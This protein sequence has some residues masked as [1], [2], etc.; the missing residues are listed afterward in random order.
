[1]AG[2]PSKLTKQVEADLTA[3]L[4]QGVAVKLAA[5]AT[6]VSPRSVRRWLNEGGLRERVAEVRDAERTPVD[7]ARA[8]AR[9]VV[10]ILKAAEHDWRASAWW[11][12]RRWPERWGDARMKASASVRE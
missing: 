11:L 5:S 7:D 1:M 3:L 9:M 6:E 8:E 12:E 4:A 2:R 10:L